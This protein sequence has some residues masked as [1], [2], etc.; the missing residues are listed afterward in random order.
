VV[1]RLPSIPKTLSSIP[2]NK[3]E[4]NISKVQHSAG[5]LECIREMNGEI[6]LLTVF[7]N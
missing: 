6:R 2:S 4:S 5:E 7:E 3:R 1:E